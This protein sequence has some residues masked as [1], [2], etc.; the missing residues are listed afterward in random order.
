MKWANSGLWGKEVQKVFEAFHGVPSTGREL[1][2]ADAQQRT[3]AAQKCDSASHNTDQQT[4]TSRS[5]V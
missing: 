4:G 3:T 5:R 1:R 2:P